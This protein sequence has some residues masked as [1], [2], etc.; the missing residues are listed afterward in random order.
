MTSPKPPEAPHYLGHRQRLRDR[1]LTQGP[2]SLQDY[3]LLEMLLFS[4][5][6]RQDVK[7]IAKALLQ[8]YKTL[9]DVLN[10]PQERLKTSGLKEGAI[11]ALK[12]SAAT[13]QRAIRGE[14]LKRPVFSSWDKIVDYCQMTM[15]HETNEQL[16]LFFLDRRNQVI[17]E[18]VQQRGTI[19]HTPVY[20]REVVKRAL[21]IGAGALILVHNHPSGD[22]TPSRADVDI[23]REIIAAGK[24]LGI[25]VHDHLIVGKGKYLSFKSQGLL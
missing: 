14:V 10:A 5:F 12:I 1:F 13:A 23:T 24:P 21:E 11:A 19:D 4:A 15:A 9:W 16:R 18:E 20:P 22:P 8:E 17:H 6:P 25:T 7:P 3:E 2:D